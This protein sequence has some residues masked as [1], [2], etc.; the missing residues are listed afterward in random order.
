[1]RILQAAAVPDGL[2][3]SAILLLIFF[4]LSHG[5]HLRQYLSILPLPELLSRL[6]DHKFLSSPYL[7]QMQSLPEILHLPHNHCLPV[8]LQQNSPYQS[9]WQS[10]FGLLGRHIQNF[11]QN[12]SF[13]RN[14]GKWK[15]V[16]MYM[17][18][19]QTTDSFRKPYRR[20]PVFLPTGVHWPAY[21]HL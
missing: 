17:H 3:R 6:P 12:S 15:S 2:G 8:R 11:H 1:M 13:Q 9:P 19:F 4:H 20:L 14:N 10:L 7:H 18:H 16:K 21:F 5:C